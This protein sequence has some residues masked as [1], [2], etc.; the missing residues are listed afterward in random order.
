MRKVLYILGQLSDEDV[1]WLA[2][3]GSRQK[4]AKGR[5]LVQQGKPIDSVYVLLDGRMSVS[6]EKL[7]VVAKLGAGEIIGEMSLVDSH[8]ASASVAALQDSLVLAILQASIKAKLE[9]DIGFAARFYKAIA[10][11]LSDRMRG[12]VS[13]LGYGEDGASLDDEVELAGELDENVLDTVHLAGSRFDRMLK[14]LLGT[15]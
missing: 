5:T 14:K 10:T 7:G 13:R 11:F 15:G 12:T 4:V 2:I 6:I 9:A 3:A 8:P 1:D